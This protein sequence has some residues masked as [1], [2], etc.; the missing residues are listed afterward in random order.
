MYTL[1]ILGCIDLHYFRGAFVL[2]KGLLSLLH[3]DPMTTTG[4]TEH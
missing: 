3:L 2:D 4:S 1:S